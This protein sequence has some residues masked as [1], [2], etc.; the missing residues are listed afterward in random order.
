MLT[1]EYLA[2]TGTEHAEQMALMQWTV[3]NLKRFPNLDLL[4]AIPNGG[5]RSRSVAAALK[6]E[7]V[8]SGVPDL[9]LPVPM[10]QFAGLWIEMK[11]RGLST[12][13]NGGR[14]DNQVKWHPRLIEQHYAV[15]TCYGWDY[16]VVAIEAYYLGVLKMP[17][18][19]DC[20]FLG[21]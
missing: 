10:G 13:A 17:D 21:V 18:S 20:E 4:F 8:K 19:G 15:V 7:G 6:A 3:L 11:K 14:L 1:P 2:K 12:H 16:A 9:F 5:D